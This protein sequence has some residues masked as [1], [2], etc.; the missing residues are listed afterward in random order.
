LPGGFEPVKPTPEISLIIRAWNLM[1]GIDWAALPHVAEML[2]YQDIELMV[3][4]LA[5]IR[6]FQRD[7]DK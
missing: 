1:G 3:A 7:K 2:G 4:Q 6:D 5:A